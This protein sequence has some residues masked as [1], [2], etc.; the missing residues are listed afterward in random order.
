MMCSIGP[1]C[2]RIKV[3]PDMQPGDL[4]EQRKEPTITPEMIEAGYQAAL[5]MLR[6]NNPSFRNSNV[7]PGLSGAV[8]AAYLAMERVRTFQ[9]CDLSRE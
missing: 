3:M 7:F 5:Q 2:P 6:T 8:C 1:S 9:N 4:V